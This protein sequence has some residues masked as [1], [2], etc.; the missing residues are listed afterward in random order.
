[1]A[2]RCRSSADDA[3]LPADL[4]ER[5]DSPVHVLEAVRS[6][7]LHADTRLALG[8]HGEAEPDHE[9]ATLCNGM[10]GG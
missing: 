7:Q 4:L 1:M 8:H 3:Q 9:D 6:R 2:Q 10:T 5:L